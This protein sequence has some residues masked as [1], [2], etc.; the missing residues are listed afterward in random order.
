MLLKRN[1]C[2]ASHLFNW[3][4][5]K[6]SDGGAIPIS[7]LQVP[8]SPS[9]L[10]SGFFF[11]SL[12]HSPNRNHRPGIYADKSPFACI[13]TPQARTVSKEINGGNN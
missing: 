3:G 2:E 10:S 8:K 4:W 5:G 6:G 12:V 7:N 13:L 1:N 9:V 11:P